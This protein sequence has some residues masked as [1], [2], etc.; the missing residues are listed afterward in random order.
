MIYTGPPLNCEDYEYLLDNC[1]EGK[2]PGDPGTDPGD[3]GSDS[4]DPGT[5]PEEEDP[6]MMA[7]IPPI[8]HFRPDLCVKDET[9]PFCNH[10]T[11]GPNC[12][13]CIEGFFGDPTNELDEESTGDECQPCECPLAENN[14]AV[15]CGDGGA[16]KCV[17]KPNYVGD[18]CETCGPGYFGMPEVIGDECKPCDCNGNIDVT[19]PEACNNQTGICQK[20]LENTFGDHCERCAPKFFGDAQMQT[21]QECQCDWTGAKECD[22]ETGQCICF[23]GVEGDLCD[24]CKADHWG[25]DNGIPGC[26]YCNCSEASIG[27]SMGLPGGCWCPFGD[28]TQP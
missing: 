19:D 7:V 28:C 25:F 22:H 20:C 27:K 2:G 18:R 21:C 5:D 11:T 26:L 10:N 14:F 4:G 15:S 1:D 9:E 6:G 13:Q 24:R 23:D 17:C 3:P 8:C 16:D 12:E